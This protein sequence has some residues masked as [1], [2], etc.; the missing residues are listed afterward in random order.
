METGTKQ[1][2]TEAGPEVL[3]SA[4]AEHGFASINPRVRIPASDAWH[5]VSASRHSSL[6]KPIPGGT[7]PVSAFC[8]GSEKLPNEPIS[9]FAYLRVHQ[10]V[11]N[12]PTRA[13]PKSEPKCQASLIRSS[14]FSVQRSTF[15]VPPALKRKFLLPFRQSASKY[16][17]G[18]CPKNESLFTAGIFPST[19]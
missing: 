19:C 14:A 17:K 18:G 4:L 3:P 8:I 5:P 15:D 12:I 13:N 10:C 7:P 2:T 6:L 16:V 9:N 1:A 11:T